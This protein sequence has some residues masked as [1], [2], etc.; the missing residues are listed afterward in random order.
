MKALLWLAAIALVLAGGALGGP[1]FVPAMLVIGL[2]AG[3]FS[4]VVNAVAQPRSRRQP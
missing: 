2:A 3:A 4:F 1:S